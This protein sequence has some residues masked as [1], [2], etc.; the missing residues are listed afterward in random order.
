MTPE[1]RAQMKKQMEASAKMSP[2]ERKKLREKL[3]KMSPQ[4]RAKAFQK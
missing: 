1:Q 3:Q 4:D 2:E